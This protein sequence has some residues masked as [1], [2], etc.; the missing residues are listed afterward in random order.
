RRLDG[1]AAHEVVDRA[2]ADAEADLGRVGA[3]EAGA[4]GRARAH[5]LLELVLERGPRCLV[6]HGVD[7]GQVVGRDVEHDLLGLQAGNGAEHAA[8]HLRITFLGLSPTSSKEVRSGFQ[9]MTAESMLVNTC[10]RMCCASTAVMT[11]RLR[12]ETTNA[13]PSTRTTDSRAPL[14]A[15]RCTA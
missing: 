13:V 3:A 11:V 7:V 8:H 4:R 12:T 5:Q 9:P 14:A 15:A 10:S 2:E 1:A 6:A